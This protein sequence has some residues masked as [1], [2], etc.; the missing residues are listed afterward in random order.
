MAPQ[1][2]IVEI[3]EA[4]GDIDAARGLQKLLE[5]Q[6]NPT[7]YTLDKGAQIAEIAI[8][9]I[10]SPILQFVRGQNEKL[11]LELFFDT[12]EFGMSDGAVA[13]TTLTQPFYQL[14]KVQSKTHA[15]PRIQFTWGPNL[16]FKAI[17]ENVRQQFTLFNPA[18]VPLRATVTLTLREYRTLNEQLAMLNLQSPDTTRQRAVRA[19][20]T[21]TRIAA[22]EY[23]DARRWREIA[24]ANPGMRGTPRRPVPGDVLRIP[25]IDAAAPASRGGSRQ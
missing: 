18:G 3:L 13:V 10:D 15:P 5:V 12:T 16:S 7:E 25:P 19:A 23:G 4:P 8:P 20:E 24:D 1:P 21:L 2:A 6:F 14:V 22:Q 9:G 11:T 17:V